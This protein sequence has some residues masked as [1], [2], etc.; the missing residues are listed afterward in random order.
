MFDTKSDDDKLENSIMLVTSDV[1]SIKTLNLR[2]RHKYYKRL[3]F[4]QN[5]LLSP[6]SEMGTICAAQT[7]SHQHKDVT[8]KKRIIIKI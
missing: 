2:A 5:T 4:H 6:S 3:E 1:T 8:N 7:L